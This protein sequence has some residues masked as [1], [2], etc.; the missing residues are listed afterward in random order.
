MA[1]AFTVET[2][3][4]LL[5]ALLFAVALVAAAFTIGGGDTSEF[6]VA[7]FSLYLTGVVAVGVFRDSLDTLAWQVAFSAGVVA[8][9]VYDVFTAGDLFSLLL[10][11]VGAGMLV[12]A[13][14]RWR[15]GGRAE[16]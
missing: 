9:G 3:A 7:A 4:K 12:A 16:L 14:Y 11:L 15:Q 2:G 8:W 1:R 13:G 6:A 10:V 5:A